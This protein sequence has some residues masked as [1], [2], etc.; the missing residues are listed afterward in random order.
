MTMNRRLI[1]G[2]ALLPA[3]ARAQP[4]WLVGRWE[5]KVTAGI[6]TDGPDRV[7]VVRSVAADGKLQGSFSVRGSGGGNDDMRLDGETVR[8]TGGR[9]N[10]YTLRRVNPNRMEGDYLT[11]RGRSHPGGVWLERVRQP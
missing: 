8:I 5:G 2:A 10:S 6:G 1:L 7:L 11:A 4:H 3:M 9:G